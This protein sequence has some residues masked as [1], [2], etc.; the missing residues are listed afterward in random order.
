MGEEF[1]SSGSS[2]SSG[3]F[4]PSGEQL[5]S[6][7]TEIL[8]YLDTNGLR[9]VLN[10]ARLHW[11]LK[12]NKNMDYYEKQH[13]WKFT[14]DVLNEAFYQRM[15]IRTYPDN[16]ANEG[17]AGINN[18]SGCFGIVH[19]LEKW[20]HALSDESLETTVNRT[21]IGAMAKIKDKFGS[22][23]DDHGNIVEKTSNRQASM[24]FDPADGRAYLFTNDPPEYVNN[25]TRSDKL[26]LRT[27]AR[28]G[29]IPTHV[30][31]LVNDQNFISDP[32][33]HHTDNNFTNSNRF[34]VDNLDD[35]TFVYPE[36]SKDSEGNYIE[37]RRVGL[38]GGFIYGEADSTANE[39]SFSDSNNDRHGDA[40][41][42]IGANKNYSG[43]YHE[44]G[45]LPG[46][47]RSLEELE[48]VD[49]I[50]QKR[51]SR[52][53]QASP[54][55]KRNSNYYL[56]D[57]IW[58]SEWFNKTSEP[59]R[60]ESLNPANMEVDSEETEPT[61]LEGSNQG[62][63]FKTSDL[64]QWRYNR[65]LLKYYSSDIEINILNGGTGYKVNDTL[66]WTF[67][68]DVFFFKVTKVTNEGMIQEGH[69]DTRGQSFVFDQSPSTNGIGVNFTNL[70][71]NG[72]GAKLSIAVKPVI[73]N[74]PTQ[75]KNNLYAFV[76]VV[77]S[78]RSENDTLWSDTSV[79][80]TYDGLVT[81]RST[82]PAPAYSG[83]NAGRGGPL[84]QN[85]TRFYE[86]GGNPTAGVH[87]HLFHYVINTQDPTWVIKDGIKVYTGRWVDMGPLGVE[88]PCDIKALLMS[89][90][91]TNCFNNYYKFSVDNLIDGLSSSP[92][93]VVTGNENAVTQAFFHVDSND[94]EPN[95]RFTQKRINP[96]TMQ[97][98]DV[99]ITD[100]VLFI[101]GATGVMFIY[102]SAFK[103]DSNY[104]YAARG[105][106]WTPVAGAISR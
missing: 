54:G 42:S 45:Y 13:D 95:Q 90:P 49:L 100:K 37:N 23:L 75:I 34:I 24:L 67:G 55:V 105:V 56:L 25:Q 26:P 66:R 96:N 85:V 97:F 27:V 82:A 21:Q 51:V 81:V 18:D 11:N 93:S 41:N 77:P 43:I 60:K 32:D 61:P 8:R 69:Y 68:E 78:V 40:V 63:E 92:D 1:S 44:S 38:N 59:T 94:P 74:K 80:S 104:G 103:N 47:F 86:H 6:S 65:V 53:H 89:N 4:L 48:K 28:I 7:P 57:G 50:G 5:S 17:F 30:T 16:D 22:G 15:E 2:N 73:E 52:I 33:Y 58:A 20:D 46:I 39:N 84:T 12:V 64:Y 88:R 87:L 102:N 91:D 36:V 106:G 9:S 3:S 99:D 19:G 71:G 62:S 98:E 76:D 35:R 83:V 31:D 10:Q 79:P 29:D 70:T 101:N 14:G 72:Y